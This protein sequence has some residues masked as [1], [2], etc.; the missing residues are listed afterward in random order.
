MDLGQNTIER[1]CSYTKFKYDGCYFVL[2]LPYNYEVVGADIT[3]RLKIK[4]KN[5][6]Y[7]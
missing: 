4:S 6:K 2:Y 1:I 5:Y 7:G 3:I